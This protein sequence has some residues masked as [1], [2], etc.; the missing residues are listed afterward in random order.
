M[1]LGGLFLKINNLGEE[2]ITTPA[3]KVDLGTNHFMNAD[4]R[5]LGIGNARKGTITFF[6]NDSNGAKH[7]TTADVEFYGN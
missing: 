1:G 5:E 2:I 3:F 4:L 6:F 7:E